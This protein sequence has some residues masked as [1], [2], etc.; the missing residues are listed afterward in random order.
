MEYV[1]ERKKWQEFAASYT[2]AHD[3]PLESILNK[4]QQFFVY[5]V[6]HENTSI[7]S[8]DGNPWIR[9]VGFTAT[10]DS[11]RDLARLA[12]DMDEKT[13]TRIMP[14]GKNFL[15]GNQKYIGLDLP[16]REEEQKKSNAMIDAHIA[17]RE[18]EIATVIQARKEALKNEA[19]I[20]KEET[21][22]MTETSDANTKKSVH[23][24]KHTQKTRN[25]ALVGKVP[26]VKL[27]NA[28]A[29]A[30]VQDTDDTAREPSVIP[31]FATDT[32]PECSELV[33][34]AR[35]SK[36]LIHFDVLVGAVGEWLPLYKPKAEKRKQQ[37]PLWQEL[38][39]GSRFNVADE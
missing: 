4:A 28:F 9:A 22:T 15:I 37:H 1:A 11:A 26:S 16:R 3:T 17:K 38:E 24:K 39:R 7:Q 18:H 8:P 14:V 6:A 27:Q 13:E 34:N 35:T 5:Q 12:H 30:V 32:E 36:D 19:N 25:P 20:T 31:L 10:L 23:D 33:E 2:Q 21:M 29:I